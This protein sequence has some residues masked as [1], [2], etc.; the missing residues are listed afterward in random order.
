MPRISIFSATT[1]TMAL[2]S[3]SP[4]WRTVISISSIPL[5]CGS[6]RN[7][8]PAKEVT[9]RVFV[10]L[11]RNAAKLH[12]RPVLTG[13]LHETAH[14]FAVTTVR[15]EER[16]PARERHAMMI[17]SLNSDEAY[18]AWD[19]LAP[20]LDAALARLNQADR[21]AILRRYFE[22]KSAR[23]KFEEPEIGK[24]GGALEAQVSP[25]TDNQQ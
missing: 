11:A 5:P 7:P 9:Q 20:D 18:A 12:H 13:W 6:S 4:S 3:L 23:E 25:A 22:R 21:E 16:R 10:A 17:D 24:L 8:D 1:P 2:K 14:S 19:R 15:S